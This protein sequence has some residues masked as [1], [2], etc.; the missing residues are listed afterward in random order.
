MGHVTHP[1]PDPKTHVGWASSPP[2]RT[3]FRLRLA[4]GQRTRTNSFKQEFTVTSQSEMHLEFPN[5]N[6]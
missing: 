1:A 5:V 6:H 4:S 2:T 3:E